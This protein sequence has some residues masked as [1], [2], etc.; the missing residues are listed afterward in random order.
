MKRTKRFSRRLPPTLI[1]VLLHGASLIRTDRTCAFT[2]RPAANF[3]TSRRLSVSPKAESVGLLEYGDDNGEVND[4][5]EGWLKWMY[6]G[7]PRHTA[8]VAMREPE[9]L[10]GLPRSDR[11]SSK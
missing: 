9:A 7:S 6:T 1:W 2:F 8:E 11:Y 5:A 4:P 10:G 3:I